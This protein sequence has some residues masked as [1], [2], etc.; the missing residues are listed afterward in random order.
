M[1]LTEK[2]NADMKSALKQRNKLKLSVLRLLR[3]EI[4][5]MEIEKKRL[6][7][8]EEIYKIIQR[9]I[10]K[11]KES[12]EQFRKGSRSDLVQQEEAE[13]AVLYDYL[14]AQASDEEIRKTIESIV[15]EIPDGTRI[16]MGMIMPEAI[17]KLQGR[18]DGK[19]I[20][21]IARGFIS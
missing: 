20:S 1:S 2:L 3:A 6:L 13:L 21:K 12:I 19:R 15:D 7:N 18:A 9:E 16:N 10:K 11:R 14:P 5:N 8:D 4:K 17:K